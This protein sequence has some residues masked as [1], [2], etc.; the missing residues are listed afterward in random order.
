MDIRKIG[1]FEAIAL[2]CIV[3]TNQILLNIPETIIQQTGSSAWINVIFISIVAIAF[4]LIVCK[5][6]EKF[7]GKDIL[8]VSEYVGGNTLKFIM[9]FVYIV[10][11]ILISATLLGYFSESL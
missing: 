3:I 11:I 8:D 9:G 4:T 2:V 1:S 7:T 10:I 6:F 5:L